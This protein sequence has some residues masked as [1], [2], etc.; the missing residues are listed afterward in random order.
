[1]RV[2]A[3]G[4]KVKT[5][6]PVLIYA[7]GFPATDMH[8]GGTLTPSMQAKADV[9]LTVVGRLVPTSRRRGYTYHWQTFF[10]K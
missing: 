4:S 2:L 5:N 3:V 7:P 8:Q 6:R 9:L 10:C 1:M